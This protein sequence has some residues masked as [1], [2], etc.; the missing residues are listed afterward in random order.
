MH[1][2]FI[3]YLQSMNNANSSNDNSI[4]ESQF[5][6]PFYEKVRVES[7]IGNYLINKVDEKPTF[8]I[9]TGHAGDGKTSL[10]HQILRRYNMISSGVS[11]KEEGVV[12]SPSGD[13]KIYY[14][15]DMS[16]LVREKQIESIKK[17]RET[18]AANGSCIIVS[19]TGTLIEAFKNY[20]VDSSYSQEEIEMDILKQ[21]DEN[22]FTEGFIGDTSVLT[23]NLALI[24]NTELIEKLIDNILAP[25]LWEGSDNCKLGE[26]CPIHN[27]YRTLKNHQD[28]FKQF[29]INYYRWLADNDKRLTIRQIL[30]HLSYS[31]TGNLQCHRINVINQQHLLFDYH[32]SNLFFGYVGT[33]SN[34]DALKIKSISEIQSMNL[35]EKRLPFDQELFVKENFTVLAEDVQ[36]IAKN[37][38]NTYTKRKFL[39]T[40]QLLYGE[41][42]FKIRKAMR[43]MQILFSNMDERQQEQLYGILYSPIYLK[44]LDYR[45]NGMRIRSKRQVKDIMFNALQILIMG[46]SSDPSDNKVLYLPLKRTGLNNQNVYLIVGKVDF[47]EVSIEAVAKKSPIST[48]TIYEIE[49]H[50]N[51]LDKPYILTLPLL[52]YFYQIANGSL[53]TKLNPVLSHGIHRLKAQLYKEYEYKDE[54]EVIKLLIHTLQGPKIIN[55]ELDSDNNKLYFE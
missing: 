18:I 19:N 41:S 50:F 17:G 55:I 46:E 26:A 51:S 21:I 22:S 12:E 44:Y 4:A 45:K 37:S 29:A 36:E 40:Q 31:I 9:L 16:E 53:S 33:T 30:S 38:W 54:E 2:D 8:I 13:Q 25:E 20:Y 52:N 28:E 32:I 6:N 5:T 27:N 15:K 11:L 14:V 42:L 48:N 10:L 47:E 1:I 43:R 49:M 7:S 34:I 39:D 35:D 23:I 3:E 24:D